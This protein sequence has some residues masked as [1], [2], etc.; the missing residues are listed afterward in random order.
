MMLTLPDQIST[1]WMMNGIALFLAKH[2]LADF[3]L[4]TKWM[5]LGKERVQGWLV[6]L[7]I[8]AAVHGALTTAIFVTL[9]PPL[10]WI[11]AVDFAIHFAIDRSKAIIQQH[12]ALTTTTTG[13][14]WLLGTDQTLHHITH[15]V[16]AI[17]LATSQTL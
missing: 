4:Q 7:T 3:I 5:A 9:A 11:G 12:Y 10:A 15:L 17:I 1:T 14:W 16:F 6:P 13:F 2:L 8:H